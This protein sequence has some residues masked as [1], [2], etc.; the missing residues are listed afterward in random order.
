ML[1]T[2]VITFYDK[3]K[4]HGIPV[5]IDGGWGVDAL[6]GK[7]SR[8]H[9]DLD[10]ALQQKHEQKAREVLALQGYRE[11]RRDNDWNYVMGDDSGHEIDF[12][13]FVFDEKN[14]V[15]DGIQYP[16]GALAGTG[17]IAGVTVQCISPQHMVNF[18][19]GYQ[20]RESDIQDVTALCEK[21]GLEYPTEYISFKKGPQDG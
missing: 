7:Q 2:D 6:L 20:L 4:A 18:H 3:M 21:F 11:V 17:V 10:I 1:A 14:H 9:G 8:P 16:D 12:H 13:V 5:W 19:T 15:V